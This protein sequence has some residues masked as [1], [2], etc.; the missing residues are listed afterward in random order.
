[1]PRSAFSSVGLLPPSP[2][3]SLSSIP[4]N[5]YRQSLPLSL[6]PPS[7]EF[8]LGLIPDDGQAATIKK[9]EGLHTRQAAANDH[10]AASLGDFS[11]QVSMGGG[12]GDESRGVSG[13]GGGD[14]DD[15]TAADAEL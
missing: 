8:S 6:L 12:G 10:V 3:S 4:G 13:G 2:E 5:D 11:K 1:M 9:L 14:D 7:P 15:D